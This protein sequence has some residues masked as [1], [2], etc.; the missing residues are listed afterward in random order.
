MVQE[1]KHLLPQEIKLWREF[2]KIHGNYFQR[3][4]YDVHVGQ[5]API[6]PAMPDNWKRQVSAL[7]KFR[8]DVVGY[9]PGEEWIIEVKPEA[10][11]SS[12][13]QLLSYRELYLEE[14]P[15]INK[16]YLAIVTNVLRHDMDK[17]FK[18]FGIKWY[19]IEVP[20]WL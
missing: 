14:Y 12:I 3:F 4:E 5:G 19:V 7:S 18:R 6:D 17:L 10:G 15:T 11:S 16:V 8:I 20:E 13:G 1:Y 9:R 2:I